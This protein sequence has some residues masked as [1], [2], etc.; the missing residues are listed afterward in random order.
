MDVKKIKSLVSNGA[1]G[2]L[3]IGKAQVGSNGY[4]F[5]F[6]D[7]NDTSVDPLFR[8]WSGKVCGAGAHFGDFEKF[9][10]LDELKFDKLSDVG[11]LM[12]DIKHDLLLAGSLKTLL[13]DMEFGGDEM[14]F[15]VLMFVMTPNNQFFPATFYYGPSGTSLGGWGLEKY[16]KFPREIRDEF[17]FS[18]FDLDKDGLTGLN[19]AQIFA[20]KKVPVSDFCGIYKHDLGDALMC[21]HDGVA[22]VMELG[23]DYEYGEHEV[24]IVLDYL[25]YD[26]ERD[27]FNFKEMVKKALNK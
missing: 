7:L 24:E 22:F 11:G 14:L 19:E 25:G 17:N 3:N 20:L 6:F 4:G 16:Q 21:V 12:R 5:V 15:D 27:K 9:M 26:F 23:Y 1:L 13:P 10:A 2:Q 18:P 8:K